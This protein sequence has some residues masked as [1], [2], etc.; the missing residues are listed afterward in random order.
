MVGLGRSPAITAALGAQMALERRP[1]EM[2]EDLAG[3]AMM[4]DPDD[5]SSLREVMGGLEDLIQ[6]V[7]EMSD[8]RMLREA[9]SALD[10]AGLLHSRSSE[11]P[12]EDLERLQRS[13]AA[14][15]QRL[16]EPAPR[17]MD[18]DLEGKLVLPEW[19]APEIFEDFISGYKSTVEELEL[20]ILEFEE[21]EAG[22]LRSLVGRVHT[23]KGEAGVLGLE[24]LEQ[25]CHCLEDF[26]GSSVRGEET[27]DLLLLVKDWVGDALGAYAEGNLPGVPAA[28]IIAMIKEGEAGGDPPDQTADVSA[29]EADMT[30][31]G[32]SVR[33]E[34][35]VWDADTLDVAGE[36]LQES[37]EGIT[38]VDEI[39]L[40]AEDEGVAGEDVD[41]LFRV[42]HTIKG[43]AGFLEL[44]EI[45]KLAHTTETLLDRGRKGEIDI[46]GGIL[47]LLFDSTELMRRMLVE[48]RG[49]IEAGVRQPSAPALPGLLARLERAIQGGEEEEALPE[50]EPDERLGDILA[51]VSMVPRPAIEDSLKAQKDTGRKL[52]EE[53]VSRKA[54]TP[55]QVSQAVRAQR[56]A[57]G[58]EAKGKIRET[59]KVDLERVDQL[60]EMIGELVI[61]ESMV[62]NNP[63][64]EAIKSPKVRS[65]IGQ[66]AKI[67][68]DLQDIG[69]RMRM[70]PVRGVFQKMARMVRDLSRKNGKSITAEM[71]GEGTEMDRSMVEQIGDPLV[72]MIRNAVDHGIEPAEER[73]AAG[74]PRQGTVRLSAY[75]EGGSIVIEIRDDG[76]G[77]NRERILAKAKAQH[78][79]RGDE[80]LCDSDVFN[81]IFAPGFS[82]AQKVTDISGRGVGMD[83]VKRN[84][85]ALRGRVTISSTQGKGTTF[86][87]V[88]PLTLAIIEGML[89]ATGRDQYIIPTLS[90]VESIRPS[91]E[92]LLTFSGRA[93]LI[94]VRGEI[95]P[96]IRLDELFRISGAKK[97]I[98]EGLVVIVEGV[99]MRMGLMVDDVLT[100]QQVVI[101]SLGDGLGKP[102]FVS[103][104]AILSD[105]RVGLI[106]NI[107][108]MASII[109]SKGKLP[110]AA[111]SGPSVSG[112]NGDFTSTAREEAENHFSEV[113]Q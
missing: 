60:V 50:A 15:Q 74:K 31:K 73:A 13:I 20:N 18:P 36:F 101:K 55:K 88:L 51:R 27:V 110:V 68:H 8:E 19:V 26:L 81:L 84:I 93:E 105:G 67:T 107:D 47:D 106:L 4:A 16:S 39:L 24:D 25:V 9:K 75:H 34:E 109:G 92:M 76:R 14:L 10:L 61:V 49:A 53:L 104:A 54:A 79:L 85:D 71:H 40:S 86:K 56:K 32:E 98:T 48:L 111:A 28:E 113:S 37:E 63:E 35:S 83:V 103:G 77:L 30:E 17:P 43:V 99:G 91:Q 38:T 94:N 100:Q 6:A 46:I 70:V 29:T 87:I 7:S 72:H 12:Q 52:G 58:K 108:E 5:E 57:S 59:V 80:D 33:A 112:G 21:G 3:A 90:I 45:T 64:I 41:A 97:V 82:T 11:A 95:L 44:S 102:E 69:M 78:L 1:E 62:V 22:A 66:L 23:L 65:H 2:M 42:F 96:L 89:V